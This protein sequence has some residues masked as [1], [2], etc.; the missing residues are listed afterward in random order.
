MAIPTQATAVVGPPARGDESAHLRIGPEVR[1]AERVAARRVAAGRP[2]C[3]VDPLVS[4]R[5][6]FGP[7]AQRAYEGLRDRPDEWLA[8]LLEYPA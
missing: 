5:L 6:P 4:H 8:V 1:I 7:D 2:P 3:V